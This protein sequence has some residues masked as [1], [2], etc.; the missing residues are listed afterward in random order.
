MI[1]ESPAK[2]PPAEPTRPE[3]SIP[4]RG[5][6]WRSESVCVETVRCVWKAATRNGKER[7]I[8]QLLGGC[9]HFP[10]V[11]DLHASAAPMVGAFAL[12]YL[13]DRSVT[14]LDEAR[15]LTADLAEA[16]EFLH[17]QG[18]VHRDVKRANVRFT[19]TE[20]FLIDLD[21]AVPWSVERGPLRGI[22]GT[23]DWRAPE[24]RAEDSSYTNKIDLYGLGLV[25][26]DE[27]L[28]L[29][30]PKFW[31]GALTHVCC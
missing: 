15:L 1:A 14:S 28:C 24:A 26:F 23:L 10:P 21:S 29:Y 18:Y 25:L 4:M 5:L 22:A 30:F 20:A 6:Q 9:K 8:L 11:L 7:E 19:G 12:P 31:R 17:S 2:T 27:L 13:S 3:R 16:L